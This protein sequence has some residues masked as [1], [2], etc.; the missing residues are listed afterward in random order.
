MGESK[1]IYKP[2]MAALFRQ[3][4]QKENDAGES[5]SVLLTGWV[6]YRYAMLQI[7]VRFRNRDEFFDFFNVGSI[8][9]YITKS[10]QA[11]PRC[12]SS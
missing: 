8:S 9:L 12:A 10:W 5:R 11:K 3:I 2:E 6:Q 1:K 4:A 7:G